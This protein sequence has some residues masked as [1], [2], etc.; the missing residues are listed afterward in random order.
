MSTTSLRRGIVVWFALIAVIL[1][2]QS[3]SA[4]VV[5]TI[6]DNFEGTLN[7]W[8]S[9]S[10]VIVVDPLNPANR[11]VSFTTARTGGD[12]YSIDKVQANST[13][14]L[15]FDYLGLPGTFGD[16]GGGYLAVSNDTME[17]WLYGDGSDPVL[18]GNLIGDGVWRHYSTVVSFAQVGGPLTL[19]LE[20]WIGKGNS[21]NNAF[22]D[23]IMLTTT[24][25]T[26]PEPSAILLF[27]TS[28]AVLGLVTGLKGRRRARAWRT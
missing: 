9:V 16:S 27:G 3:V 6:S 7:K 5:A 23:N 17:H 26:I 8:N 1:L 2:E 4:A 14:T 24:T 22:F 11:V 20:D 21:A 10:A 18:V 28:A 25:A 19:K 15:S 13:Y 12:L